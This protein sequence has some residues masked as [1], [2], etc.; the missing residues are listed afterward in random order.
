[1]AK[2][3]IVGGKKAP[4]PETGG[5]KNDS[6][7]YAVDMTA[8]AE[9]VYVDL[10][11]KSKDAQKREDYASTHCTTFKMVR[12]AVRES[13]P[14]DPINKKYAL[15]G[16]LSNIFRIKKGR[17]RICWIASSQIRRVCILFIS[18]TLRKEGDLND[19]YR[20]FANMVMSG[21]FNDVFSHF[22]VRMPQLKSQGSVKPQ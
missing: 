6:G 22:G 12:D 19:P 20:I 3:R 14:R 5:V 8:A 21:Q 11:R 7:L 13:I 9:A 4:R 18:E 10:Y 15:V 2:P 1:V 16:D 17:L